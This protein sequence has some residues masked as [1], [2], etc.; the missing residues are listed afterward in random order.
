MLSFPRPRRDDRQDG[1]VVIGGDAAEVFTAQADG[2]AGVAERV[3]TLKYLRAVEAVAKSVELLPVRR[4]VMFVNP[5]LVRTGRADEAGER[6]A[7][8][9]AAFCGSAFC[10][11]A[12]WRIN[13]CRT[14]FCGWMK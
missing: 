14:T 10:G 11:S 3:F 13:F 6:R 1:V 7:L 2:L 9:P 5:D 8:P 4:S 12:F